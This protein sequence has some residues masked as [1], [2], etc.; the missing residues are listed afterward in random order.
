M[1]VMQAIGSVGTGLGT[2]VRERVERRKILFAKDEPRLKRFIR[3]VPELLNK[4]LGKGDDLADF[5]HKNVDAAAV[6]VRKHSSAAYRSAGLMSF[7]YPSFFSSSARGAM[8]RASRPRLRK[9][10]SP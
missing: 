9:Y 7:W 10:P 4:A 3:D 8:C 1:Q 2:A 6:P 5:S